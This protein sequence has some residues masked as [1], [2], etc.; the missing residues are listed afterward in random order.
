MPKIISP[1]ENKIPEKRPIVTTCPNCQYTI[2]YTEDEVERVDEKALGIYCPNCGAV[3]ELVHIEA[4]TFPDTFYHYQ[5]KNLDKEEAQK[6]V[7]R[8]KTVLKQLKVGDHTFIAS[9]NTIV[10]GFKFE[11]ETHIYVTQDYWEE[12]VEAE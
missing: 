5:S 4:F 1:P 11:D 9:G 12:I 3:I 8:M 6:V 7:D 10:F 2:S